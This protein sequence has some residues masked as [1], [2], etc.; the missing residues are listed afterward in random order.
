M[1][2]L[3]ERSWKYYTYQLPDENIFH[4]VL[5]K[6][7]NIYKLTEE[8]VFHGLLRNISMSST[9][10]KIVESLKMQGFQQLSIS[11]MIIKRNGEKLVMQLVIVQ[12]PRDQNIYM[13]SS[14]LAVR[15]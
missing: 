6:E 7:N 3:D 1:N 11:R 13:I 9:K 10:E 5:S 4:V 2:I 8:G 15:R 14:K 12:V